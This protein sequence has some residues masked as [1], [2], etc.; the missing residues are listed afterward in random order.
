MKT[1]LIAVLLLALA[2][3][4]LVAAADPQP[5]ELR[6]PE[7]A[8]PVLMTVD[9][10]ILPEQETFDGKVGIDLELAAPA[11][12]LWLNARHLEI[13]SATLRAGGKESAVRVV[14]GGDDFAGFDFGRELPAG[15]AHLAVRYRGKLDAVETEGLFRQKDGEDWY[16]FSQFESTFARRAFPCFDEPS[17]KHPLAAHAARQGGQRGGLQRP[18]GRRAA[19]G[20]RDEGGRV[21][22]D[23]ADP[24]LPRR[25]RASVR[26]IVDAGVW[27]RSKTPVRIVVAQGK[28]GLRPATRPRSPARCSRH[29]RSTSASPTRSASSTSRGAAD[30]RLRRDGEPRSHHLRRPAAPRRRRRTRRSRAP[31]RATPTRRRTSSPTMWFGDLVTMPWWDDIW[32]NEGFATWMGGKTVAQW[33]P[34]WTR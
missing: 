25:P 29:S 16:A 13:Q 26:S 12:F 17:F 31:A 21:C 1:R 10:T 23:E 33:K 7:V 6:L 24:V 3:P 2:L 8:R 19:G 28:E 4:T 11:S 14:A 22:A 34:E 5:P 9:L 27:G 15:K 18:C 20:E 32:L 30:G